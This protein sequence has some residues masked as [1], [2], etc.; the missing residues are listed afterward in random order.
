MT[1]AAIKSV[2]VLAEVGGAL[3]TPKTLIPICYGPTIEEL[4]NLGLSE[5]LGSPNYLDWSDREWIKSLSD[6]DSRSQPDPR[7]KPKRPS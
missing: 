3:T 6:L 7:R 2:W 5:L 1:Y 4:R